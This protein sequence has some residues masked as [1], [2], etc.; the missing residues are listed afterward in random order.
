M[1]RMTRLAG[2]GELSARPS[3]EQLSLGSYP[4]YAEAQQVVDCLAD[5]H[6]EVATIDREKWTHDALRGLPGGV[7]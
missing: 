4:T 1:R 5:H 2:R 7:G 3:V 6:F